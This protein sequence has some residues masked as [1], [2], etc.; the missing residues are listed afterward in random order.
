[1]SIYDEIEI[2]D[3]S[4]D[5]DTSLF[6]FPCP[7]GDRFEITLTALRNG[8]DIAMCPSC[9]LMIKVIFEVVS[10]CRDVAASPP[11]GLNL[12]VFALTGL[13]TPARGACKE[14]TASANTRGR[15]NYEF[16]HA[17]TRGLTAQ[18]QI[19][20]RRRPLPDDDKFVLKLP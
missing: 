2:E 8:D 14:R 9:S 5:K 6:H 19:H 12:T 7:C 18:S 15:V 10:D 16:R 17:N 20:R 4:F 13:S 1:M 3:M 11:L